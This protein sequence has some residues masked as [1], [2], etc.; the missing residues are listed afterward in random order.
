MES[1]NKVTAATF[2]DDVI[3]APGAVLVEFMTRW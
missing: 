3:R 1:L 2:Q